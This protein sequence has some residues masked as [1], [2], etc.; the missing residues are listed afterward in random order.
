MHSSR[1][2]AAL[3]AARATAL[4]DAQ[5][6]GRA[7]RVAIVPGVDS[8]EQAASQR[9]AEGM[10]AE[11]RDKLSS[12]QADLAR[13]DAEL[14]STRHQI[15]KLRATGP[16]A[17]EQA[18]TYRAL[19][20]RKY[21]AKNDY[22][23]KEQS[24]LQ[25]EHELDVQSSHARELEAAVASQRSA[26]AS[27]ASQFR[28]EQLDTLDKAKQQLSQMRDDETKAQTRRDLMTLKA[29]V[30]G[31]VQQL[32]VHTVG[33]V[34]T[35]AQTLME[36]V[37]DDAMEV[38]VNVENKDIGFV[39]AGQD[40]IVK[41]DAFPYT[42]YGFLQG[43]VRAVSNDAVQD[44]KSGLSFVAHIRLPTNRMLIEQQWITLTPGM[45]V[46]TEIKTGTRSV[47]RYFLDPLVQTS[48]ESLRER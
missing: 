17:R 1:L 12:A 38:E 13:R 23:D 30:T 15:E 31:T 44:K 3:A 35:T 10:A 28:R 16:L 42:R 25:Q 32:M 4:L 14:Q 19:V 40:A 20:E 36:I 21:V 7:P 11:Y 48:Q 24:A 18:D 41:V 39:H 29:P 8:A 9:L 43:T 46:T 22:L 27:I 37:P 45:A 5:Q 33:G 26:T 6:S 47:A 2:V 34:V